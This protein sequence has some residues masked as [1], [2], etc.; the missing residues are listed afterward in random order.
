MLAALAYCITW[1]ILPKVLGKH[2][3]FYSSVAD[4]DDFCPYPNPDLIFQN[5][6]FQI[7]T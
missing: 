6:Q 5:V 2:V 3:A 7:L 1:L 4:P